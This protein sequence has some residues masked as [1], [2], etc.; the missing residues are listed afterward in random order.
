MKTKKHTQPTTPLSTSQSAQTGNGT[1]TQRRS[2]S[3]AHFQTTSYGTAFI[4]I[5][6]YHNDAT[7]IQLVD[8]DE[9]PIATLSLNLP[10][11]THLLGP[12][13]FFAKIYSENE[14]IA[15]DALRSGLFQDT[16]RRAISF[17]A[18]IWKVLV[19]PASLR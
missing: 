12:D 14:Q 10:T 13:E 16:G 8:A 5:L 4:R 17:Q 1:N 7:A 6:S 3:Q 18:P 19:S 15:I 11:D 9:E 2:L